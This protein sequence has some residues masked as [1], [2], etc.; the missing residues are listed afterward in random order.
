MLT[1]GIT[2]TTGAPPTLGGRLRVAR[3]RRALTATALARPAG[4]TPQQIGAWEADRVRSPAPH[5]VRRLATGLGASP[6]W[7]LHGNADGVRRHV[8]SR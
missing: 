4:C 5:I 8:E 2:S 6:A 1:G 7:L 3:E